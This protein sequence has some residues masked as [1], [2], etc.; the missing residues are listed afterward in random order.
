MV[1]FSRLTKALKETEV[2]LKVRCG[3]TYDW[4]ENLAQNARQ[5][6][7]QNRQTTRKLNRS[8]LRCIVFLVAIQLTRWVIH[9]WIIMT[10]F[11]RDI[12]RALLHPLVPCPHKFR[13]KRR[14]RSDCKRKYTQKNKAKQ[15]V[16][17]RVET[18]G[19]LKKSKE[20]EFGSKFRRCP[21]DPFGS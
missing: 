2:S 9:V 19:K 20:R 12:Y 1:G 21:S 11:G 7:R 4:A 17:K 18:A 15:N 8:R 16:G 5:Q 14:L 10:P 13:N 6:R 3:V